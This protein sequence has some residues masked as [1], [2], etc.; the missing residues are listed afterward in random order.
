MA[1]QARIISII[2][3]WLPRSRAQRPPGMHH[4]HHSAIGLLGGGYL[5]LVC[6]GAGQEHH[7]VSAGHRTAHQ[8]KRASASFSFWLASELNMQPP[9]RRASPPGAQQRLAHQT[10]M[11]SV[12]WLWL[13]SQPGMQ[14]LPGV[15]SITWPWFASRST[16]PLQ[17][18]VSAFQ[19][20]MAKTLACSEAGQ[21]WNYTAS[22]EYQFSRSVTHETQDSVSQANGMAIPTCRKTCTLLCPNDTVVRALCRN[23]WPAAV[24]QE[25]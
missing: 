3:L 13:A 16:K 1:H 9:T 12:M 18:P 10:R 25:Q 5:A 22:S 7:L 4:E 17:L 20:S 15:V 8:D 14:R 6:L 24:P 19:R 2:W 11:F 21:I 23:I